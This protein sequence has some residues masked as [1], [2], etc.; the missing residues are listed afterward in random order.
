MNHI[1]QEAEL[2]AL[3]ML[4]D[5]ERDRI[6]AHLTTCL[7]C[8]RRI[9]E[10]EEAMAAVIDATQVVPQKRAPRWPIAVAAAFALATLGLAGQSFLMHGELDKDGAIMATMVNSHFLHAQFAAPNGTPLGAKAIY[11]RHGKWYQILADGTPSWHVV[12]IEPDGTRSVEPEHFARRGASSVLMVT[13]STPV[14]TI[15]LDDADGHIIG[16]VHAT[17]AGEHE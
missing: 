14:R 10:A 11:E 12:F 2:Y 8:T 1:D 9:G 16:T 13:P 3:G 17:L 7:D 6:D 4:D 5:V 15:E